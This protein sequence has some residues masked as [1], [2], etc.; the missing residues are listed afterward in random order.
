LFEALAV[1]DEVGGCFAGLVG[2]LGFEVFEMGGLG[3]EIL[4]EGFMEV[5]V[6]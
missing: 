5:L 2:V 6:S 1:L 4:G 3:G